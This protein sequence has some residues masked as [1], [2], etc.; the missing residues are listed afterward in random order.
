MQIAEIILNFYNSR[1]NGDMSLVHG[2]I[3]KNQSE[4]VCIL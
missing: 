2:F 4:G 1:K 3:E